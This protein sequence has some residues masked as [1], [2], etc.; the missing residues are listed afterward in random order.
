M[1]MLTKIIYLLE[2]WDLA[3][4]CEQTIMEDHRDIVL[5]LKNMKLSIELR[6]SCYQIM[7][8][9]NY[10]SRW[11]S[12]RDYYIQRKRDDLDEIPF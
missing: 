5:A 6:D 10:D 8:D 4:C 2:C 1:T 11:E 7:N 9:S 12:R 3:E